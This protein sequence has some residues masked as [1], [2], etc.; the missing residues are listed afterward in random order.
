MFRYLE[1]SAKET[2]FVVVAAKQK[3]QNKNQNQHTDA[4]VIAV[5]ITRFTI[6]CF[7]TFSSPF[8]III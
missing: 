8:K 3:Q 2:A 6:R 4:A 7:I 5:A 1:Q